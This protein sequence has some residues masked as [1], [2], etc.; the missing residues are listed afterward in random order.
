M[1]KRFKGAPFASSSR[2]PF[3]RLCR[4]SRLKLP[5]F[6]DE[7]NFGNPNDFSLN[8]CEPQYLKM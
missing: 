6:K 3:R 4:C 7:C 8:A 2:S 5:G 1:S